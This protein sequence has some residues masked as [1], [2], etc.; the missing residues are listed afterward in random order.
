VERTMLAHALATSS[1][2][3]AAAEKLKI[4]RKGLF[5]KRQRL[6]LT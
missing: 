4:T 2:L 5:L 3:E 6:G 1:D